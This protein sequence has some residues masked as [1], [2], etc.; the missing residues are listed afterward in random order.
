ME[1]IK[2]IKTLL[3]LAA[4]VYASKSISC[5]Y[6]TQVSANDTVACEGVILT[7]KQFIDTSNNKKE[8]RLKDLKIAK[9]E[10]TVEL[11]DIRH[12][13]YRK[14]LD[15][16]RGALSD[17]EIKSTI[18]YVISFSFGAILTGYIAKEVLK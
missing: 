12:S 15:K 17:L 2:L 13:Y 18:G 4:L 3:L 9:L 14:E 5:D 1:V 11:M 6:P 8:L 10:G 7:N 16:T